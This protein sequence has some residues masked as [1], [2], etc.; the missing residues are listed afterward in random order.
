MHNILL[1]SAFKTTTSTWLALL[2]LAA[3][4]VGVLAVNIFGPSQMLFVSCNERL[5]Q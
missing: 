3:N 5:H 1:C 2:A 4:I